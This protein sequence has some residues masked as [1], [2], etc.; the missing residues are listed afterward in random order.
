MRASVLLAAFWTLFSSVTCTL[1]PFITPC[2]SWDRECLKQSTQRAL[3]VIAAGVTSLGMQPLDPMTLEVVSATQSGLQMEFR[4][5]IVRG[6][7]N[8]EVINIERY[9]QS[10]RLELQCSVTLIGDYKLGGHLLIMP[11][12]GQGRYKINIRDIVVQID[13]N[14]N[15]REAN[16]QR[17][18][19]LDTYRYAGDVRTGVHFQFQNLFGGNK[20][21]ADNIHEY[22]NNNWRDIFNE[23]APPIVDVIVSKTVNEIRKLFDGV[24]ISDLSLNES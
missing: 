16:G 6:L 23:M 20:L 3:P 18:W 15:K 22:A 5:T 19:S 24:P 11:I 10:T 1:T 12:E 13:F 21:F 7:R 2:N 4:N 8:C 9:T 14:F 17:Y